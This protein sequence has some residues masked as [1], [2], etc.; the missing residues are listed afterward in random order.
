MDECF[1]LWYSFA[2]KIT[3][4]DKL[5]IEKND[6]KVLHIYT[7]ISSELQRDGTSLGDQKRLGVEK[8]IELGFTTEKVRGYKLW[9]EEVA[10]SNYEDF[11]NRPV[12][13]ELLNTMETGTINHLYAFDDDRLSRNEQTQFEIKTALT[14]NTV[15]LYTNKSTTDFE[16]PTDRLI[17]SVFDAFASY[18]NQ[19]RSI[20]TRMGRVARVR[21][22]F[23]YGAPPPYGYEI[24]DKKLSIHQEES[25]WVQ[26]MFKSFASG[27][28]QV[29][30]K[31][32]L[33]KNGVIARRGSL[34][35]V[36]SINRLFDNTH[37]KGFFTFKDSLGGETLTIQCPSF[38]DEL[39]WEQVADKKKKILERKNQNARTK[40]FYLLRDL[41]VCECGTKMSGRIAPLRGEKH[42]FC[43]NKTRMWKNGA[44][45]ENEKWK[46]GKVGDYG[47]NNTKSMNIDLTDEFVW[48]NVKDIISKS[49]I[50]KKEFKDEYLGKV[51]THKSYTREMGLE[52]KKI[53]RH[54]KELIQIDK[55]L[56]DVETSYRMGEYDSEDTFNQIKDNLRD[57]RTKVLAALEVSKGQ[58]KTIVDERKWVDWIK[59][60]GD[61]IDNQKF[62]SP[63][64]HKE[65]LM[66]LIDKIEVSL[67]QDTLEHEFHIFY[68]LPIVDDGIKYKNIQ[69]KSLGYSI[70]EGGKKSG[71]VLPKLEVRGRK[72]K[73]V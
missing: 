60:F 30:I 50:L 32:E 44:I 42:Y 31:S 5:P 12:M 15:T 3:D 53:S 39:L 46:R 59:K 58:K 52:D 45:P 63:E 24:V 61:Q 34:F 9:N 71:F 20:R 4:Y 37:Y 25:K 8:S 48:K 67:N 49:S 22:G 13:Y 40:N 57:R 2:M 21:E 17:K 51:K 73:A 43:A 14:K 68:N 10:S 28:R 55:T 64:V 38:I 27:K 36:G 6:D 26:F 11:G 19:M 16:N 35:N 7:R 54:Q 72:K 69:K 29:D 23:W 62:K 56:G 47:C 70:V 33:D 1:V 18:E 66:G 41:L 65:Y